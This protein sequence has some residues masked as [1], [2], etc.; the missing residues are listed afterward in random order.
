[1][2][3]PFR[4]GDIVC[5]EFFTDRAAEIKRIRRAMRG[6]ER[7]L[8]YGERRQ[9]K[10][11][12]IRQ[13]S[14]PIVKT[15]GVVARADLWTAETVV[16]VAKRI[17]GG[18]PYS[19]ALRDRFLLFLAGSGLEPK[20]TVDAAGNPGFS[21]GMGTPRPKDQVGRQILIDILEGLDKIA[22]EFTRPVVVVLDEVQRIN[23]ITPEGDGLLRGIIQE[24]PHLSYIMAGSILSLLDRM[25]APKGPLY[26]VPRLD[27]GPIDTSHLSRWVEDRMKAKK[28]RPEEGCGAA[29]VQ[30]AGPRTEDC[31]RLARECFV[32]GQGT[33]R[34][35][36][37]EIE[38]AFRELVTEGTNAYQTLWRE[39]PSYKKAVLRAVA[40][41]AT[42]LHA[43]DTRDSHALPTSGATTKA[44]RLLRQNGYLSN[45]DPTQIAD[46]FFRAWILQQ[47]MPDGR[48]HA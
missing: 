22:S 30:L 44:V 11:S 18:I 28:V 29:I 2:A 38:P 48:P 3:I 16:E 14:L 32:R 24:T 8:V 19:W 31:I 10:S 27:I 25:I 7:L 40:A 47:A 4:T 13:A 36:L 42:Q 23:Q 20:I 43:T 46:P 39:L 45:A 5:D 21:L 34:L 17:V 37:E 1:M 33:G 26:N 41:G 6:A 9:G 35:K 12:V 15:G